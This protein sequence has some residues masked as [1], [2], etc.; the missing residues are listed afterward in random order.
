VHRDSFTFTMGRTKPTV[1]KNLEWNLIFRKRLII[2]KTGSWHKTD[3]NRRFIRGIFQCVV[4]LKKQAYASNCFALLFA[5]LLPLQNK[6]AFVI[7]RVPLKCV[8][9]NSPVTWETY[10]FHVTHLY[11]QW[12]TQEFCSEGG[13]QQIQLRTEDRENGDLGAVA[14]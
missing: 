11:S 7:H 4:P 2:Q 1:N 12:R 6:C 3:R 5:L 8:K 13:V 14:P 9:Y 10:L